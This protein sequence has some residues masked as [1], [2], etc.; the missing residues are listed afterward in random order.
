MDGKAEY[1]ALRNI[2]IKRNT[3]INFIPSIADDNIQW[4]PGSSSGGP[5]PSQS[6]THSPGS[7]SGAAQSATHSLGPSQNGD[8]LA[9]GKGKGQNGDELAKGKG[10]G[11]KCG[12]DK[13]GGKGYKGEGEFI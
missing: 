9:K 12:K 4:C 13:D 10:K 3:I 11:G 1:E 7:S 8:E 5:G 6:A 2:W